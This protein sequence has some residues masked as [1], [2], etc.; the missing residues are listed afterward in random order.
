MRVMGSGRTE[1][2]T[3]AE[4]IMLVLYG[5]H[6]LPKPRRV[7]QA[8]CVHASL[9]LLL[10]ACVCMPTAMCCLCLP[11]CCRPTCLLSC[12]NDAYMCL[13]SNAYNCFR[14]HL[15]VVCTGQQLLWTVKH[16][17]FVGVTA[18]NIQGLRKHTDIFAGVGLE[19]LQD[20]I[21]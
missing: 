20:R 8:S 1:T 18:A 6:L 12:S 21:L 9:H 17:H 16:V 14:W 4:L 15:G 3:N 2:G 5:K 10:C 19:C 7:W 11:K 13:L